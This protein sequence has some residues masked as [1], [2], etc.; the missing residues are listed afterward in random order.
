MSAT[1]DPANMRD[2]LNQF[3]EG[4]AD[5]V[6]ASQQAMRTP[7][8]KR[9]Y[10]Q[11]SVAER[12]GEDYP[13]A[14]ELDGKPVR[15]PARNVLGFPTRAAAQLVADEF[16]AQ[17]IE[18]DPAEMPVTRLSNTAIDG[19]SADKQAVYEDILRFAASD[20]LCYRAGSPAGLVERQN[21]AWDP[22]VDWLRDD[23]GVNLVLAEGVMHVEQPREAIAAI[24]TALR[25]FHTVYELTC[26]HMCTTL[27]GSAALALAL[28]KGFAEAGV[29]WG[30]AH[31]DE[32]W[33]ISQWGEDAEAVARRA[34]RE[35]EFKAA[36]AMLAAVQ[37]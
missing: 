20:L 15:T 9:F 16:E 24:G 22:Y 34:V 1:K 32:D 6:R 11:A 29:V 18:I 8:P 2:I 13:A 7:L 30:A 5:P 31:V 14:V 12:P 23:L 19:V 25:Q 17:D 37:V 26:L 10:K 35:K 21:A 3:D 28:A 27:T 4:R 33:N 36:A